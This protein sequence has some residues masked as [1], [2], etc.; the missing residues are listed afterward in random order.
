MGGFPFI[1]TGNYER[2]LELKL[3]MMVLRI[4]LIS[5]VGVDLREYILAGNT[6]LKVREHNELIS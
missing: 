4:I 5:Y 6:Y 3:D 2:T 1:E